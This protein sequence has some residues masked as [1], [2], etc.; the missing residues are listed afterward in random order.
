MTQSIRLAI[1]DDHPLLREGVARSLAETGDVRDLRRRRVGRRCHP[2]GRRDHSPT[3]CCSTS[4]C[5]AAGL[6]AVAAIREQ[7]A[8]T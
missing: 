5:R 2:A 3:S 6:H 1:V 4:A 8:R 7:S